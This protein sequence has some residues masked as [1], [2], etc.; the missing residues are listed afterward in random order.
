[1]STH[2]DHRTNIPLEPYKKVAYTKRK[3]KSN[4]FHYA[5]FYFMNPLIEDELFDNSLRRSNKNMLLFVKRVSIS[6]KSLIKYLITSEM[7]ELVLNIFKTTQT[8][9]WV[10]HELQSKQYQFLKISDQGN[11]LTLL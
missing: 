5:G 8:F 9:T 2:N 6:R 4:T 11:F 7:T 10:F 3:N 1:M